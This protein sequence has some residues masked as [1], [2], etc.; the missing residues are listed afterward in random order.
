MNVLILGGNGFI[1]SHVAERFRSD[2]HVVTTC[3]SGDYWHRLKG[4]DVVI[5]SISTTTPASSNGE[6]DYD[7][8]ENLKRAI[9]LFEKCS[10]ENI[11]KFIF[12][13]S[14]GAIYGQ[15]ECCPVPETA[16]T[17]PLCSY[18]I[19]KLAIEKYLALFQR[20]HG[21]DYTIIRPSNP[22]G[23]RQIPARGQGVIA[24]ML[25][26]IAAR[27]PI[28]IYGNGS[29]VRDFIYVTDLADAIYRAAM[30]QTP[31]SIF[32]VGSG[33][34]MP[35]MEVLHWCQ[36]VAGPANVA[37]KA[38]RACDVESIWLDCSRAKAELDWQPVVPFTSGLELTWEALQQSLPAQLA[39]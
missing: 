35:I 23:P 9:V 18:G 24:S 17:E 20:L 4:M 10:L 5:H 7:I 3:R 38:G 29:I 19:V 13:S 16:P 1:G 22:F 31:S 8:D 2:G 14:G 11:R 37:W 26:K 34:G 32:N 33:F 21:L 27:K 39:S 30:I 28:E 25:H 12:I 36:S 15:P 6:M